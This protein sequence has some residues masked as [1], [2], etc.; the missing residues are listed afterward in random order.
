LRQ[1][2]VEDDALA[3]RNGVSRD[4]GT[5]GAIGDIRCHLGRMEINRVLDC[6]VVDEGNVDSLSLANMQTGS[7][8]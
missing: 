4:S 8:A 2:G 7:I 1:A 5:D 6:A 3:G